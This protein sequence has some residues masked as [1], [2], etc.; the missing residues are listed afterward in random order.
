MNDAGGIEMSRQ[1]MWMSH[2]AHL[3]ESCHMYECLGDSGG[4]AIVMHDNAPWL[5]GVLSKG[6]QKPESSSNCAVQ[7][8]DSFSYWGVWLIYMWLIHTWL[9]HT[10]L[11][12][13]RVVLRVCSSG[14]WLIHMLKYATHLYVTHPCV[15]HSHEVLNSLRL[16]PTVLCRHMTRSHVEVCDLSIRDSFMRETHSR[17]EVCDSFICDAFIRD[18][19]TRGSQ[20]SESVSNCSL[21]VRDSFIRDSFTYWGMRL[22]YRWRVLKWIVHTSLPKAR[23]LVQ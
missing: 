12:E 6:S 4:P 19:F 13:A 15:T 2:V 17:V 9:I 11:S 7:V 20:K 18:S 21:Q 8:R 22:I 10:R 5:V 16:R 3:N 23:V 1:C 14:T